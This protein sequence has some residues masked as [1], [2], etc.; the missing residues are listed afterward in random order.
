MFHPVRL[1]N[2]AA[3]FG[4]KWRYAVVYILKKDA[5]RFSEILS[6]LPDCSTKVL[7]EVLKDLEQ[8]SLIDRRVV[9]SN[10]PYN[11]YALTDRARSF[12]PLIE[13]IAHVTKGFLT[14]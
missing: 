7:S 2:H 4:R 5:K 3:L 11:L 10:P 8:N 14:N 9:N 1:N 6:M 13:E 12:I